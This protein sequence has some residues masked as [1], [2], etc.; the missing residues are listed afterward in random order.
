M[1]SNQWAIWIEKPDGQYVATVFAT[2]YTARGAYE[3]RPLSLPMW[4]E[5]SGWSHENTEYVDAVS[6]ATPIISGRHSSI[7]DCR[8]HTGEPVGSGKYIFRMEGNIFWEHRVVW[9]GELVMG[10]DTRVF[11][12]QPEYIPER[13]F[14]RGIL[15]ED[16]RAEILVN[17]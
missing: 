4:R 9:S 8:D 13:A 6:A 12:A 5:V 17:P 10:D 14:R 15:L 16:V 1:A 11:S 7:W 2:A 3:H